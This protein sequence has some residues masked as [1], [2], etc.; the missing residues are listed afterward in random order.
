MSHIEI[1]ASF[2]AHSG[3]QE[4]MLKLQALRAVELGG[5]IENGELIATVD[6]SI[7]DRALHLIEQAGGMAQSTIL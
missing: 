3:A 5:L 1:K 7:S 6:S 4:A 2:P